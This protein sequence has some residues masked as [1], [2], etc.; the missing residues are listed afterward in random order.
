[1]RG[2]FVWM[3]LPSPL[4]W[5]GHHAPQW[6]LRASLYFMFFVELVAPVLGL[7]SG[8]PRLISYVSLVGLM[9]GIGATG[10]WGY[11]NWGYILLCTCL[12]DVNASLFDLAAEP[13]AGRFFHWPD[14]AIHGAMLV[15]FL[16][17]LIYLPTN[18]WFSRAWPAYPVDLFAV[19]RKHRAL[20]ERL[21]RLVTPARWFAALRSV[22]GYGVFPP[23]SMAPVRMQ[24]VLEGS[25]DGVTWQQYGYKHIPAF[26]HSRPPY[27]AP[28]HARLDQWSFYTSMG[29]DTNSMFG[30]VLPSG[31]PYLA[32]T[33]FSIF[34]LM[35]Q[36]ILRGDRRMLAG[37]GHN[38]F[39]DATPKYMRVALIALTPTS[40]AEQ[41]ATGNWWH[42]RRIG[43]V[44]P[45]RTIDAATEQLFLPEPELF[46]PEFVAAKRSARPLQL[47]T[48]AVQSGMPADRAAISGSDLSAAQVERFWAEFVPFVAECRGDWSK[49]HERGQALYARYSVRDL[50]AFDRLFERFAWLLMLRAEPHH[51]GSAQPELP[52]LSRYRF[53]KL[54]HEVIL[55]G[56]AAYEAM[57]REPGLI[58]ARMAR[59]TDATQ[60]WALAMLRYEQLMGAIM[61][62]RTQDLVR[63]GHAWEMPGFFEYYP[64]LAAI[65]PPGAT[66]WDAPV[67]HEDGEHTIEGFYPAP[68]WTGARD[69]R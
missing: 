11:F 68:R 60:L 9:I 38:P 21:H 67:L 6:F 18:S 39:P 32:G 10:S 19:P 41:R 20:V 12:L 29:I 14:L 16:V 37:L 57:L 34:D 5:L 48:A 24:P 54:L 52:P 59:S 15:T 27:I 8:I 66:F 30:G 40:I 28:Y 55:D 23:N 63:L 3:P 44:T 53:H 35:M 45:A 51:W 4:G 33:R 36:N 25:L 26:A 22:N 58:V 65:T 17:S 2:F 64:I 62:V 49:V 43:I 61:I 42:T 31:N 69:A 13:W 56:Q 47:I 50:H 46:H 1:L 7:F